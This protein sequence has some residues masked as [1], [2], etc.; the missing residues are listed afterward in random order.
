MEWKGRGDRTKQ[1]PLELIGSNAI[2]AIRFWKD[3]AYRHLGEQAGSDHRVKPSGTTPPPMTAR[4]TRLTQCREE[5]LST[6]FVVFLR[7]TGTGFTVACTDIR[8]TQFVI[9]FLSLVEPPLR[10]LVS[11]S[12]SFC[13]PSISLLAAPFFICGFLFLSLLPIQGLLGIVVK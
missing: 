9:V 8:S 12:L 1:V 13:L 5:A 2:T 11:S 3:P 10:P 6:C 7:L 4:V